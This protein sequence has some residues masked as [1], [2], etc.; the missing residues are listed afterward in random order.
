MA[1]RA[2]ARLRASPQSSPSRVGWGGGLNRVMAARDRLARA[3]ASAS[4]SALGRDPARATASPGGCSGEGRCARG[5][6]ALRGRPS[7][8]RS[9]T[10]N[11]SDSARRERERNP[12][13][14]RARGALAAIGVSVA[15]AGQLAH[16]ASRVRA[17]GVP[18]AG[19]V[20]RVAADCLSARRRRD[21]RARGGRVGALRCRSRRAHDTG[22]RHHEQHEHRWDAHHGKKTL[23]AGRA[24]HARHTRDTRSA[25]RGFR[26]A[27][28]RSTRIRAAG[29][30]AA[31]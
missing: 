16:G 22:E 26:V 6:C 10:R 21:R 5:G 28:V 1:P 4:T 27:H 2:A 18:P 20:R 8:L 25:R 9:L 31:R 15:L 17:H 24:T 11:V 19:F 7:A 23:R 14:S 12:H 13:R 30:P 29:G 3:V